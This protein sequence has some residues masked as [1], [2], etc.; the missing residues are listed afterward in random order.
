VGA[1]VTV[2]GSAG[3]EVNW[4]ASPDGRCAGYVLEVRNRDGLVRSVRTDGLSALAG[5]EYLGAADSGTLW[6]YPVDGEGRPGT[7]RESAWEYRDVYP[8]DDVVN[9]SAEE[10]SNRGLRVRWAHGG[11]VDLDGYLVDI[12]GEGGEYSGA[13][14]LDVVNE[15]GVN[16]VSKGTVRYIRIRAVDTAG[17]VSSG[18]V[19]QYGARGYDGSMSGCGCLGTRFSDGYEEASAGVLVLNHLLNIFILGIG[20]LLKKAMRMIRR[21][22]R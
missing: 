14:R 17:N 12:A 10:S 3:L 13:L 5:R 7:S 18:T 16:T 11:S 9:V 6:V 8:P 4:T 1:I 21:F 15:A 22:L 20:V 19:V 2:P